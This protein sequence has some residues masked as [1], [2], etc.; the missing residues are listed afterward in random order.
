MT[1]ETYHRKAARP[2]YSFEK[3]LFIHVQVEAY[4][5]RRG[6]GR[7]PSSLSHLPVRIHR[8]EATAH[9]TLGRLFAVS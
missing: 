6:L 7:Q 5:H 4:S 2:F 8:S 1:R 3:F 9:S